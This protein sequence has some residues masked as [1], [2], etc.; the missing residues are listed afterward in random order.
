[1]LTT[2]APTF[3]TAPSLNKVTADYYEEY[4]FSII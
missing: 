2:V 4:Y 3:N 1:M